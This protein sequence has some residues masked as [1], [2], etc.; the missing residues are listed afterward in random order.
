LKGHPAVVI[1]FLSFDCPICASYARPLTELAKTYESK[2]VLF[3]GISETDDTDPI[4]AAR[5]ARELGISFAVYQ[6][7]Q[8]RAADALSAR[9]TPEIFVLDRQMVLRYRGRI[10]NAYA[11]RTRR[12]SKVTTNDLKISLDAVLA[13]KPVPVAVTAPVGCPI[14]RASPL[15]KK[16]TTKTYYRDVLPILQEHCQACHRPGEVGP[17]SLLSY[18]EAVNW[19]ADIKDYTQTHK[20][21]PWKP[22]EGGPFE[23]ERSLSAE[24]IAALAEWVDGGTP[25]GDPKDAPAPR[26][27]VA[28]WQLGQPDLVLEPESTFQVGPTGRDIF[29]CFVMPTHLGEDKFVT[30][31]EVRPSNNRI[32]HHALLFID[33]LGQGRKL[34]RQE[35]AQSRVAGELDQGPGYTSGMGVGFLPRGNLGGWA[36]GMGARRLPEGTCYFLP[37]NADVVMQ[38]HYHRDGKLEKDGTRIGLYFAKKPVTKQLQGVVVAGA[39]LGRLFFLIP[40]GDDHFR[41][42]GTTWVDQDCTVYSVMPHMHLLG[43]EV[44]ITMTPP[45]GQPQVL[46]HVADWDYNWQEVYFFKKKIAVKAGTRFDIDAVYDNSDKNPL[47]PSVPP[48]LVVFGEQT[49]NEMCFGFIGATAD[50][51][52]RIRQR[53]D[54]PSTKDGKKKADAGAAAR[55]SG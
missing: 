44:A 1:A 13:G 52:G 10:D 32:A 16:D 6:D 28:G 55:Q 51:P 43:R 20:M 9:T 47:N 30:A 46:V 7:D 38:M 17:F 19:A 37:K 39:Q 45:N 34:E 53:F 54:R 36:P 42:H 40:P 8:G 22:T 35:Q 48:R 3:V 21:P 18:R 4:Q 26:Q 33:T 24:K 50:K 27:F 49:T 15:A 29:R 2:G 5:S 11:S 23:N 31:I 12:N 14:Q 41:L 25:Q